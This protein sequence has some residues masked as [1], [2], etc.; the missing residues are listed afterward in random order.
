MEQQ[1]AAGLAEL[2]IALGIEERAG[3]E[4]ANL[5]LVDRRVG[6]ALDVA[7]A[8]AKRL[9]RLLRRRAVESLDEVLAAA[10]GRLFCRFAANLRRDLDAISA[11]LVLP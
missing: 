11:A 3:G 7:V 5:P 8:W 4:F 9:N 10:P 6:Q 2:Q 1:L